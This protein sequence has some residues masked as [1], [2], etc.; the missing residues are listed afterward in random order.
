[1]QLNIDDIQRRI[2]LVSIIVSVRLCGSQTPIEPIVSTGSRM[3]LMYKTSEHSLPHTGFLGTYEGKLKILAACR[4]YFFMILSNNTI[5]K[6]DNI[7]KNDWV[8]F[9]ANSRLWGRT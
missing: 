9:S 1:M 5:N 4:F 8:I 2:D 6:D 3:L 7:S